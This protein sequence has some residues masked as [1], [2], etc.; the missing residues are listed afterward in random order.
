MPAFVESACA[1][2]SCVLLSWRFAVL[3][4]VLQGAIPN[5]RPKRFCKSAQKV[6][7]CSL[8][9]SLS[10]VFAK[11]LRVGKPPLHVLFW[12]AFPHARRSSS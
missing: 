3:C 1:V 2:P 8:G 5:E 11:P 9:E 4:D 12:H 7:D 10:V 6:V